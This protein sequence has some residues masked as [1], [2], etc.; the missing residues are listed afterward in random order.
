MGLLSTIGSVVGSAFGP[1]GS[2]LGGAAGKYF[3]KRGDENRQYSRDKE[4]AQ[5]SIRW[6]VAD[7]KAAGLHPLAAL[8]AASATPSVVPQSGDGSDYDPLAGAKRDLL[9]SQLRQS[10]AA[11]TRD[12]AEAALAS[13]KIGRENQ[14]N[15]YAPAM[16]NMTAQDPMQDSYQRVG[17]GQW[18]VKPVTIWQASS[19]GKMYTRRV[20]VPA[21]N[22]EDL[23]GGA[24]AETD[25]V[26]QGSTRLG[27]ESGAAA[28]AKINNLR[29]KAQ[30]GQITWK[31]YWRLVRQITRYNP[32]P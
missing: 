28:K 25:A 12:Y 22:M 30:N 15:N 17:N 23:Y 18:A 1:V 10:D 26:I 11:A 32:S 29:A 21:A 20:L 5:K 7:A 9:T 4:F 16:A 19:D 14:T 2:A 3:D 27:K 8:G 13:S 31:E 24:I 6:K